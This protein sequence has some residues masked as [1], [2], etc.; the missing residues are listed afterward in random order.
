VLSFNNFTAGQVDVPREVYSLNRLAK[1]TTLAMHE[2][3]PEDAGREWS[4]VPYLNKRWG[5][6]HLENL[7]E[8]NGLPAFQAKRKWVALSLLAQSWWTEFRRVSLS[9]GL[10]YIDEKMLAGIIYPTL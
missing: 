1:A 7:L 5:I 9:S 8:E 10:Q 2:M 3:F 6:E 4:A